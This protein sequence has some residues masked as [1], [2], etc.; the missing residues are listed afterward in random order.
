[1][2]VLTPLREVTAMDCSPPARLPE[3]T[4]LATAADRG[5]NALGSA[6]NTPRCH[7]T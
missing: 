3:P 1:M 7:F 5:T 2:E 6:V 4:V